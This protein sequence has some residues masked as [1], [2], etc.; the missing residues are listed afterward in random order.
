MRAGWGWGLGGCLCA[1]AA[2]AQRVPKDC[3]ADTKQTFRFCSGL[4]LICS[5][6]GWAIPF[7]L[8]ANLV[9]A[10]LQ[11]DIDDR[12]IITCLTKQC[13]NI[14]AFMQTSSLSLA[15]SANGNGLYR[16]PG[17]TGQRR[18]LCS[19]WSWKNFNKI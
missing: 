5:V 9:K 14:L 3:A 8:F 19:Y 10:W 17:S 13:K 15:Y 11:H 18:R 7:K 16:S 12:L 2:Y 4:V 1:A 6:Q